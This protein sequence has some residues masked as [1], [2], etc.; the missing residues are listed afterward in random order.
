MEALQNGGLYD[1]GM[2]YFEVSRVFFLYQQIPDFVNLI[3]IF[4][5]HRFLFSFLIKKISLN[6]NTDTFTLRQPIRKDVYKYY[7]V[8][9]AVS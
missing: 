1:S 6:D 5:F 4:C 9:L 8:L 2:F 7:L 3:I